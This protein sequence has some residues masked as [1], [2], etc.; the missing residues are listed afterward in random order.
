MAEEMQN[1]DIRDFTTVSSVEGYDHVVLSL[2][3]GASAK[4]T[5]DLLRKV[6][7]RGMTPSIAE[8]GT[9]HIGEEATGVTAEG[10][11]PVF[12]K[13][14]TAVEWKYTH[15]DDSAWRTLVEYSEL[16]IKFDEL[17][18][19]QRDMLRLKYSDLTEEE[20]A[21]LQQPAV[22]MIA[23]L[24]ETD[25]KVTAA[26]ESRVAEF[27]RIKEESATAIESADAATEAA[28]T[29]A[30]TA[31]DSADTANS[32]AQDALAA[33]DKANASADNADSA[34]DAA[35]TAAGAANTAAS[36]A[37]T[38]A[39]S[40]NS[41]ASKANA[42]ASSAN[43]AAENANSS[44]DA[45]GAAASAANTA[46]Q[47]ATEAADT[48]DVA[49]S[50]ADAATAKANTAAD[51]ADIATGKANEATSDANAA[52]Q[53]ALDAASTADT[54]TSKADSATARA[55]TSADNADIATGKAND[56]ASAANSATQEAQEAT[57]AANASA[58]TASDA[59]EAANEAA[60]KA[61]KLP[62]IKDG[63]WWL[64]DVDTDVY[65][66]SGFSVST[67]Y[68]LTREK[69]ENVFTGNVDS[70]WHDRYVDKVEGKGL[71]TEDF[72]TT[73]K[74]KLAGLENFDPTEVNGRITQL[75]EAMPTKVSDLEND[76]N[77]VTSSVLEGK[78]YATTESLNQGL[79]LKQDKNLYFVNVTA[80]EWVLE[81][82]YKDFK[83]RCDISLE[84]VTDDMVAEVIFAME[85]SSSGD[86]AP[87]CETGEGTVT[88]WSS[89]NK[90]IV[91][92]TIIINR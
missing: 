58:A 77:Y 34:A 2:Y 52:A 24:E 61:R 84:G 88:I 63:T 86:Y 8:D 17:T 64:Y 67:D 53:T 49:T 69:I 73:E 14:V 85:E 40:A 26:E 16:R 59:A 71:S 42:A 13:G 45:A 91:I 12:R 54:A 66:D 28:N 87:L 10:K 33:T 31:S 23:K 1:I 46:A 65:V 76:A 80:S 9:W 25:A 15:E 62:I 60:L 74:Q 43:A 44:A 55:N 20:I 3:G 22:D 72:T 48:A 6:V 19:E 38:A 82:A 90:A 35:N 11:T 81:N 68:Q 75:E 57:D 92:P 51:N 4:M 18:E 21:E 47:L 50:N 78:S 79:A 89:T 83:Y 37:N 56:A 36:T 27:S 30:Q 5:V 32:A 41:S 70:H 7:S 39:S 29:A